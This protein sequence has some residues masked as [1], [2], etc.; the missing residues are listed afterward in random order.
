M[1]NT[2]ENPQPGE[3]SVSRDAP[4]KIGLPLGIVVR[5][6]PGVT[7]W[8]KWSWKPVAVLP[9]AGPA[10]WTE[11]RRE[12]DAVEY[13]VVTMQLELFRSDVE[14]YQV[15]LS[16]NPPS[17][18]VVLRDDDDPDTEHDVYVH[19]VTAS[20]YE[21]QDYTDSGDEIVEAVP[22][23]GGLVAWVNDYCAAFFHEAP[24]IKRKRDI[25]RVDQVDD[26]VGDGRIRQTGDVYRAPRALKPRGKT[27]E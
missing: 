4:R 1:K 25:S 7:K 21:A 23:P 16:M 10:N 5:R 13:H 22:M 27:E 8:A 14:G 17:V 2:L 18:F 11:M 9:G 3:R 20:A 26:G 12:G 15:S 19:A 24:F 6:R